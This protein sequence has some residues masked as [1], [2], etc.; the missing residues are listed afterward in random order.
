MENLKRFFW[1][2]FAPIVTLVLI[3]IV[4]IFNRKFI[5]IE[6]ANEMILFS[7]LL[8]LV[9]YTYETR[10]ARI[11]S[12]RQTDLSFTPFVVL[13]IEEN[14]AAGYCF[15][16]KNEGVGLALY[17]KIIENN[18]VCRNGVYPKELVEKVGFPNFEIPYSLYPG[19]EEILKPRQKGERDIWVIKN[20]GT[21]KIE[22]RNLRGEAFSG[23]FEIR[24]RCRDSKNRTYWEVQLIN[25]KETHMEPK[26][27]CICTTILT[28]AGILLLLA[29]A[30]DVLPL[31]DNLVIFLAL[32]CFIISAIIK[33]IGKGTSSCCK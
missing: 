21:V 16:L 32:A 24:E 15:K 1:N 25:K 10:K 28:G 12:E 18:I 2:N 33:K 7:T 27:T 19:Q 4:A 3:I 9:L 14:E 26:N 6:S 31:T 29:A 30:F 23:I 20:G 11:S 8:A 13:K 17:I 5:K 22:Y